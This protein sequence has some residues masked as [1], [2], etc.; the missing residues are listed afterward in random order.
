MAA[1]FT[2]AP[3]PQNLTPVLTIV[4]VSPRE[5]DDRTPFRFP[6]ECY[7]NAILLTQGSTNLLFCYYLGL[8]D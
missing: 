5:A 8:A 6:T 4:K 7:A 3:N 1:K 2:L